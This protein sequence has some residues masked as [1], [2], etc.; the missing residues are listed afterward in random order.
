LQV[1]YAR[2]IIQFKEVKNENNIENW[3]NC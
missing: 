3:F 2:V 1:L